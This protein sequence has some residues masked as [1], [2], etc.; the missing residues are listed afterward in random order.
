MGNGKAGKAVTSPGEAA[1]CLR[2]ASLALLTKDHETA[3]A[4]YE[5]VL[6]EP[7]DAVSGPKGALVYLRHGGACMRLGRT[8]RRECIAS[9]DEAIKLAEQH[10]PPYEDPFPLPHEAH[11][12]ATGPKTAARRSIRASVLRSEAAKQRARSGGG[13]GAAGGGGGGAAAGGGGGY[14]LAGLG[15]FYETLEGVEIASRGGGGRPEEQGL[16]TYQLWCARYTLGLLQQ[17]ENV[18]QH[19]LTVGFLPLLAP[20]FDSLPTECRIA[21][22]TGVAS[23]LT[24]LGRRVEA[25]EACEAAEALGAGGEVLFAKSLLLAC[26]GKIDDAIATLKQLLNAIP[27]HLR[28]MMVRG[29]QMRAHMRAHARVGSRPTPFLLSPLP[30]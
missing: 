7:K 26:L 5:R 10:N 15:G 29:E 1:H 11:P 17:Q 4:L 8:K 27:T 22:L 20:E 21:S 25:L 3:K 23:C 30:R 14:G 18:T 19:A 9:L 2:T 28:A 13:G 6:G 24:Q 12:F 16:D